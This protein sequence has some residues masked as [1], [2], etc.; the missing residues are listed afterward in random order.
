MKRLFYL[1]IFALLLTT[2]C[3]TRESPV[4]EFVTEV[5]EEQETPLAVTPEN[6]EATLTVVPEQPPPEEAE[7]PEILPFTFTEKNFPRLD[8]ST[9]TR[10]LGEALAAVLLG[11]P[12]AECAQ[13]AQFSGT[14]SS[15]YALRGGEADL[16]VLYE[17]V[18]NGYIDVAPIGR[19][20]L[21]FLVNAANPVRNLSSQQIVDI[22]AGNITNWREVGG[23]GASIIAYQRNQGSGSQTMMQKLVM[24]DT[25]MAEAPPEMVIGEMGY[26]LSVVASYNNGEHALGYNVYYYVSRMAPDERIRL[27]SVDGVAPQNSTIKD[28]SYPFVNDFY[29]AV[30]KNSPPGSPER[31]LFEWLQGEEGQALIESEGYV[32]ISE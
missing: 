32:G 7:K 19:D 1:L 14:D 11:K 4:P 24:K 15:Y 26:L 3:Q 8:G 10:P 23:A 22:Y 2:A 13:Y 12:R 27:L 25:E 29:V 5:D 28:G 6:P 20:A 18:W 16:L 17:G 9:A 30:R 31:V 21:V